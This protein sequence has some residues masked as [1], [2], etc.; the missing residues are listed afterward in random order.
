MINYNAD[1][2][3]TSPYSQTP[4]EAADGL[5][6]TLEHMDRVNTAILRKNRQEA[7]L[8]A[9]ASL[10]EVCRFCNI[11]SGLHKMD[12]PTWDLELEAIQRDEAEQYMAH[13]EDLGFRWGEPAM[14]QGE[15]EVFLRD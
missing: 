8:S 12:C 9:W 3:R 15:E 2:H 6:T 1:E 13:V 5:T 10:V 7:N 14:S 4:V 11:S